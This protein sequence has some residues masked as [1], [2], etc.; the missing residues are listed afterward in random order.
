MESLADGRGVQ[1]V[2]RSYLGRRLHLLADLRA[3]AMLIRLLWRE[4]PDVL[5]TH[6]SKAGLVGRV[7]A[8]AYNA[9][10]PRLRRCAVVH[11]YHGHVFEGYFPALVTRMVLASER[12]LARTTD[13]IVTISPRQRDDIVSRY[14]IADASRV[15]IVPLGLELAP[16][17]ALAPAAPSLRGELQ[18]SADAVVIGFVGRLVPIKDV[19]TLLRAF[20]RARQ[21]QDRLALVVAG[22][23]HMRPALMALA[24]SLH[25]DSSVRFL[26]WWTGPLQTLYATFD[27]C[28]LSSVNE[29]TPVALI[30]AMAAGRA[31]AATAV[32]GVPDVVQDGVTGLLV[33]PKDVDALAK[34]LTVLA[35]DAEL[36]ARMGAAGRR[37][38]ATRY[39]DERLIDDI[40]HLYRTLTRI[41]R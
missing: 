19:E 12:L 4:Q 29:G 38:A 21:T 18:L 35:S 40:E 27:V 7:A 30:E 10:R 8:F 36:R 28:A 41:L 15:V 9:V 31:V 1:R 33:A 3:V 14:R 6:T 32:G 11:T 13:C 20:A 5:H 25:V 16:L 23:G 39:S 37:A 24:R 26:G 17:L 34:A 2:K 22:D